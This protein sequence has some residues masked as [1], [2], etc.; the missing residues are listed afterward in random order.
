MRWAPASVTD[1]V[2]PAE[3]RIYGVI[4]KNSPDVESVISNVAIGA[5]NRGPSSSPVTHG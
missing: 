1:S 3:Q 5:G 4:G 2:T